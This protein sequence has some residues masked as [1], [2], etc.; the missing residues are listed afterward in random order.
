[1]HEEPLLT[2][3]PT[4][5]QPSTQSL[6]QAQ[7]SSAHH[8]VTTLQLKCLLGPGPWLISPSFSLKYPLWA[9]LHP[10]NSRVEAPKEAVMAPLSY[11][12]HPSP[13]F[14]PR[15]LTQKSSPTLTM[16]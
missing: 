3:T 13:L 14:T 16:C 4:A 12:H 2:S 15:N 9:E 6:H 10:Q 5:L 11:L 1:M 8:S 7:D